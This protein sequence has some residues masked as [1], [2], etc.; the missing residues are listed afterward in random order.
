[1]RVPFMGTPTTPQGAP[2]G[3]LPKFRPMPPQTY[4]TIIPVESVTGEEGS[5]VHL[6]ERDNSVAP[7]PP[8]PRTPV[9]HCSSSLKNN[10]SCMHLY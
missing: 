7:Q 6:E 10:V 8:T 2:L 3:I 9:S 4:T 1:M 5:K